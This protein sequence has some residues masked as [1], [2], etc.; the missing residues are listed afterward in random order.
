MKVWKYIA[1]ALG[2]VTV[3]LVASWFLRN[4]IIERLSNTILGQ[5]D[6]T[7]TDVSLDALA[8]SNA[9]ISYLVLEHA[10][11]TIISIE[12]L[13]LPIRTDATGVKTY[14]ARKVTIERPDG[15]DD[16]PMHMAEMITQLLT[17]PTVLPQSDIQV[18]EIIVSPYPVIREL[19][20]Q[21]MVDNQQLSAIVDTISLSANIA[22]ES[23][24]A[25]SLDISISDSGG[26]QATRTINLAIQQSENGISIAGTSAIDLPLWTPVVTLLD[27]D[28][29]SVESGAAT[30]RFEAEIANDSRQ[31]PHVYADL[32]PTTA[33]QLS[34]TRAPG[35]T[36]SITVVSA[37]PIEINASFPDVQWSLR[38]AQ[39]SLLVSDGDFK[40]ISVSLVNVSCHP[41][42]TCS[43]D[44][45]IDTKNVVMPF[46]DVGR[47]EFEATQEVRFGDD[48]TLV[49]VG[50]NATLAMSGISGPDLELASLNARLA[51]SAEIEINNTGWQF[52]AQSADVDI[53]QFVVFE[54]LGFSAQVFLDE[55][56]FSDVNE[57]PSLKFGAYA[58]SSEVHRGDQVIRLPGF[59]GGI[60]RQGEEVAVFLE[61][62]GL[63]AEAS[64]EASHN[65]ENETGQLSFTNASLSF[66]SQ[67]LAS[68][69]APWSHDW[70]I[71]AGTFSVNLRAD[72]QMQDA[73]WHV[74][75]QASTRLADLAGTWNDTAFAGLSTN[76]DAAFDT[77]TGISIEP[78]TIE[79]ALIE[80]GLPIE[81]ITADYVP[82]ADQ[83][84][85]DVENLRM[86]AFGG[87]ITADPFSFS[88]ANER[89]TL[90]LHASS[91][92]LARIL[93]MNEFEAV[94]ISGRI[95]A[96]LPVTIEGQ[97]VTIEGGTLTGEPPGGVIRYLPG[98]GSDPADLSGIGI[99]TRALSNF[100]YETLTSEVDYTT[101]G[102]LNLQMRLTGRN[103]DLEENRPVI[104]N[105]GLENNIPQMLRSLQAARAV[106]EI[107][108]RKLA[109]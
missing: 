5:F 45:G 43:A 90:L 53:E 67:A 27:I 107:L 20:W 25:H 88:T 46:A 73:E 10:N 57:Q 39:A 1:I 83:N 6:L 98:V 70:N 81:N 14:T 106:E 100:E 8:T 29:I 50:P 71:S 7:V 15:G 85:V 34:Y 102:D 108:E 96:E 35:A 11:E 36:T 62:D 77:A 51:T 32:T 105:F 47:I 60:A 33:V 30:L 65:L 18:G 3:L 91:I 64:I 28:G 74:T 41:G 17:L 26:T 104:L 99:A 4:T 40:D 52:S 49:L 68:R 97:T 87:V 82:Y 84:S 24:T 48:K 103:P 31:V 66:D 9:S 59:K 86:T 42:T 16:E 109:Q 56:F 37:S 38:Q 78:S 92:D 63:F 22:P 75:A 55:I 58:S 93:A 54:D 101:D 12:D 13:T 89:N 61:T 69:V 2:V 44:V 72:W 76:V 19:R 80:L 79:V 94:E 23:D 95:G 21:L